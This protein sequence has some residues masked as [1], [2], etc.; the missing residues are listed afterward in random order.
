MKLRLLAALAALMLLVSGPPAMARDIEPFFKSDTLDIRT[1]IGPP[2]EPNSRETADDLNVLREKQAL[3]TVQNEE[4][5]RADAKEKI[6]RFADVVGPRFSPGKL[7]LTKDFFRRVVATSRA[8]VLPAKQHWNRTRPFVVD[9]TL[10]PAIKRPES[11]SWPSRHATTGILFGLVLADMIPEKRA[12]IM[13]RAH[14]FASNR[15]LA[16]VHYPSDV[17]AG[18]KAARAIYEA[19]CQQPD[20]LEARARAQ[21]ELRRRLKLGE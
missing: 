14:E 12:E 17:A 20:F 13:A 15:V 2:P 6:W 9:Q 18:E 16:G 5:V 7:P 3:R 11:G 21:R 4:R 10:K 8:V 19:L 1:I